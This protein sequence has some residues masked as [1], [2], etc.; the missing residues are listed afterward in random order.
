MDQ[1][2]APLANLPLNLPTINFAMAE[3]RP[4]LLANNLQLYMAFAYGAYK[5]RP[6][7]NPIE[8]NVGARFMGRIATTKASVDA[9]CITE[10]AEAILAFRGSSR[11]AHWHSNLLADWVDHSFRG[12]AAGKVHRG[13]HE[14]MEA[15]WPHCQTLLA[16]C[17][18]ACGGKVIR[19]TGIGHSRGGAIGLLTTPL[20]LDEPDVP[21][22]QIYTFGSP[23][24]GEW[25]YAKAFG[26]LGILHWRCEM[27][28]DPI[29]VIG[30]LGQ[31]TGHLARVEIGEEPPLVLVRREEAPLRRFVTT[32]FKPIDI[33]EKHAAKNYL[34]AVQELTRGNPTTQ[35]TLRQS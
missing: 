29:P 11:F 28:G 4:S 9:F 15:I 17:R 3:R 23:R 5:A 18:E 24:V 20:L 10:T 21:E 22:I 2:L 32:K 33:I 7:S 12:E 6:K 8:T 16:Q 30:F 14:A 26:R 19:V 1:T 13:F 34:A 35:D 31:H 25:A 27:L